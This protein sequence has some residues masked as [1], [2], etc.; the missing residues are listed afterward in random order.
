MKVEMTL[1]GDK[2]CA[3]AGWGI[4]LLRWDWQSFTTT[5]DLT[6][7]SRGGVRFYIRGEKG[8]ENVGISMKSD[9]ETP[10]PSEAES[11][12]EKVPLNLLGVT[13][14]QAWQQVSVPFAKFN[15]F[16][17]RRARNVA[18]YSDTSMKT[19]GD[20]QVFYIKRIEF[21]GSPAK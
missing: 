5:Y 11:D 16:D 17:K 8:R 10:S 7:A 18:F 21:W 13:I 19:F 20:S 12:E 1:R 2:P 14:T 15:N 9:R 6:L 3:D 4:E